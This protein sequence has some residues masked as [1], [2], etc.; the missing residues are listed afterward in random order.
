MSQSSRKQAI[1]TA[2]VPR[3][4]QYLRKLQEVQSRGTTTISSRLMADEVG[5]NPA[6]IRKDLS[7]FGEFGIRGVGYDVDR[8]ITELKKC[9]GLNRSWNVI[10]IGSGK[11]GTALALYR[12][13]QK[14]G[15]NLIGM[16][17]ADAKVIGKDRG[18]GPV[19][20]I[21]GLEKFLSENKV[22][23]AVVTTPSAAAQ[24]VIDRVVAAGVPSVL[25][26]APIRAASDQP[27]ILR[28][29]DLS[30]E[31]MTLSFYLDK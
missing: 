8:L 2:T 3:L 24:E 10:I 22:H 16:F 18:A 11:L 29:V 27:V 17:D 23:I 28:Q 25:N 31:L 7:Y 9:L 14:Q 15:F 30:T 5:T 12:G 6:Q 4:S 20:P 1:P 13:F 21:T 26:F 19:L